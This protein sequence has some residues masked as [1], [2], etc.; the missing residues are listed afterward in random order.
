MVADRDSHIL[1]LDEGTTSTRAVLF[2][3]ASRV[4]DQAALPLDIE[5]KPD[6]RTEQD[7]MELWQKSRQVLSQVAE[8]AVQ[9]GRSIAGLGM[10]AMRT[11]TVIWDRATGQPVAPLVSWQDTRC[12]DQADQLRR[13]WGERAGRTSGLHIGPDNVPLHLSWLLRHD[14]ELR[15][16]AEAGELLAGTPDTWLIWNLT[17]GVDGGLTLTSTSCASSSAGLDRTAG[18]WWADFFQEIDVPLQLMAQIV[19]DDA[20]FGLT[21][22]NLIGVATP[23]RS[24]IGDQTSAL[25]GQGGFEAGSVKCTHGTGS[26]IDF[27]IGPDP[28][29][30]GQGLDCR[31]GWRTGATTA[32]VLEGGSFVTGSGVEWLIHGLGVLEQAPLIDQ[33]YAQGDPASGLICVP[34]LAGFSAPHWDSQAR[35]LLIG[36]GRGTTKADVVRATLNGI[37]HTITDVLDAM[38]DSAGVAPKLMRLDGGLSRSETLPQ[39]QADLMQIPVERSA[40][41]EFITARGAGWAAGVATGVWDSPQAADATKEAG[42]TFYPRIDSTQRDALRAA[43]RDAVGRALGWRRLELG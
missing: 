27:N 40:Q 17:G 10:A 37:A 31:L 20:E 34:A 14:P 12:A 38:A 21:R 18:T 42:V 5:A 36:F 11:S 28:I 13:D 41:S 39:L 33:T 6:G 8:R 35:G 9:A 26:F 1:V 7:A 15:R 24:V 23:I 4:I 30:P 22:A 43:W 2:D 19:P 16:R 29:V 25:Y 32:Y 3:A